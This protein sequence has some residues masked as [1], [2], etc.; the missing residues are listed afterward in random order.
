MALDAPPDDGRS[1]WPSGV[2]RPQGPRRFGL[3]WLW[4]W[5]IYRWARPGLIPLSLVIMMGGFV[6]SATLQTDRGGAIVTTLSIGGGIVY[7]T[8]LARW[9]LWWRYDPDSPRVRDALSDWVIPPSVAALALGGVVVQSVDAAIGLWTLSGLDVIVDLL[10]LA[11]TLALSA[12]LAATALP[13]GGRGQGDG[14]PRALICAATVD[15]I[16]AILC[17]ATGRVAEGLVLGALGLGVELLAIGLVSIMNDRPP[18]LLPPGMYPG[19]PSPSHR[20]R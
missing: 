4:D 14:V 17:L 16:W 1:P 6:G 2:P 7:I 20:P 18:P 10:F 9:L 3:A 8:A 13:G 5:A 12:R 15:G 11:A 19:H